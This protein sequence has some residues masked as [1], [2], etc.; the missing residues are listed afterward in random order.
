MA[1]DQFDEFER[2]FQELQRRRREAQR[3]PPA[4]SPIVSA[5]SST[6]LSATVNSGFVSAGL[7]LIS[8]N[9]F[10]SRPDFPPR[11]TTEDHISRLMAEA[12]RIARED[13][14]FEAMEMEP[15]E[16]E[17]EED[18]EEEE[19]DEEEDYFDLP[20]KND[21]ELYNGIRHQREL[22][23]LPEFVMSR[24][25]QF[26][27]VT[28]LDQVMAQ[29]LQIIHPNRWEITMDENGRRVVVLFFEK[30]MISNS[31]GYS[32]EINHLYVRFYISANGLYNGG[33]T[34]LFGRRMKWSSAEVISNYSHSHLSGRSVNG[35]QG[36]CTGTDSI[37]KCMERIRDFIPAS[38]DQWRKNF[39]AFIM[40]LEAYVSFESLEG[41]PYMYIKNIGIPEATRT[42]ITPSQIDCE[43]NLLKEGMRKTGFIPD[44][45]VDPKS[46]SVQFLDTEE[47]EEFLS[48]HVTVHQLIDM[49]GVFFTEGKSPV[50]AQVIEK[51]RAASS[52]TFR[53]QKIYPK[54][55]NP[56]GEQESKQEGSKFRFAHRDIKAEFEKRI[57]LNI[58]WQWFRLC[59]GILQREYHDDQIKRRESVHT[60]RFSPQGIKIM[61]SDT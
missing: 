12:E 31:Q 23:V 25:Y 47:Y 29:S 40:Q 32:H 53:G 5:Q 38:P 52:F 57:A 21:K 19:A 56:Y 27:P 28:A 61:P 11:E 34:V 20:D 1:P 55:I 41:R 48:K 39:E 3:I 49:N 24:P 16:D 9:P 26:K 59:E 2:Q 60:K 18:E 10:S 4:P 22:E 7:G 42:G 6:V 54:L 30:F 14:V 17:E 45:T 50:A 35:W 46:G 33:S 43:V 58:Q 8:S 37:L 36:F 51:F 13:Q 15:E 44:Y